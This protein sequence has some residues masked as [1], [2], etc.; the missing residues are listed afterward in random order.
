MTAD[1]S[2]LIIYQTD[3][4]GTRIETRLEDETV[5]LTQVGLAEL[6]QTTR[7]N[8]GQHIQNIFDEGEVDVVSTIKKFF[9]VQTEGERKV[10]R[11]I[12]HYNLDVILSVGYRVK[13]RI[14][15]HF[16]I[17]ATQRLREYIVKGFTMNDELLKQAGGG[18]YFDEL[19]AQIRDIWSLEKVFW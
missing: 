3:D 8:I 11:E 16:R 1:K 9:I 18:N 17:W 2:E 5:W 4:G 7:Q 19:L 12:D 10:Q 13:S 6:F 14:A 15:T